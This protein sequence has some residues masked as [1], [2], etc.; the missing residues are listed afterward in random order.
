[1]PLALRVLTAL[2]ALGLVL[3]GCRGGDKGLRGR[4]QE[5]IEQVVSILIRHAFSEEG[6]LG[7]AHSMFDSTT[8]E[9]CSIAEFARLAS[10]GRGIVGGREITVHSVRDLKL[11]DGVATGKVSV[12]MDGL[13][14]SFLYEDITLIE[15][16]GAWRY[17][18]TRNPECDEEAEFFRLGTPIPARP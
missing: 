12:S 17:R 5:A 9:S 16:N 10:I 18:E 8:R 14:A 7:L 6:N 13:Q 1:M 11:T 15:E 4:D 3:V 2:A